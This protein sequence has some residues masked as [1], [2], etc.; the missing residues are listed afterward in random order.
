L[1]YSDASCQ[2]KSI[3]W[4][5]QLPSYAAVSKP[6]PFNMDNSHVLLMRIRSLLLSIGGG[7][8]MAWLSKRVMAQGPDPKI[9]S[10][11]IPWPHLGDSTWLP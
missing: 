3:I 5:T 4:K 8:F 11:N 2:S 1:P 10:A 6:K 9:A 7:R